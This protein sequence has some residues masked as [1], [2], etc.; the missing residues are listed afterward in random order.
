[1]ATMFGSAVT[2]ET[3][4]EPCA[5]PTLEA[6]EENV[7]KARRAIVEGRHAAEDF[8]TDATLKIRR[9]P[10]RA[11]AFAAAAGA[12]A[13]CLLGFVFGWRTFGSRST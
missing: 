3:T 13:G 10:L 4:G 11:V 12:T 7:R 5:R 2:G 1:M 9:H 6:L 8:A